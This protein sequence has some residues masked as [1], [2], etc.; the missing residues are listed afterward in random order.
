MLKRLLG[1]YYQKMKE[2]ILRSKLRRCVISWIYLGMCKLHIPDNPLTNMAMKYLILIL[3]PL[4]LSLL[5]CRD[6]SMAA[7][8]K[9]SNLPIIVDLEPSVLETIYLED[10]IDSVWY[11]PLE[12]KENSV[13]GKITKVLF[14]KEKIFICDAEITH[15]IFCFNHSGKALFV[16]RDRGRG[17][18]QYL[19]LT[20]FDV[21]TLNRE[22]VIYDA[23]QRAFLKYDFSGGFVSKHI[24][25]Y[26]FDDFRILDDSRAIAYSQY[27]P[28]PSLKDQ[29][30]STVFIFNYKTRKPESTFLSYN[31]SL[32][33]FSKIQGLLNYVSSNEMD[34]YFYDYLT[35]S[36]YSFRNNKFSK[37]WQLDYGRKNIP[38]EFWADATFDS[39]LEQINAGNFCGGVI[40]FQVLEKWVIGLFPYLSKSNIFIVSRGTHESFL[41]KEKVKS[42]K[43]GVPI[44]FV[45]PF[46]T[47]G[48]EVVVVIEPAWIS[49]I[50]SANKLDVSILPMLK[51]VEINSNPILQVTRLK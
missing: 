45:P 23:Q 27:I 43:S 11:I 35:N 20:G 26:V 47:T 36:I 49:G 34:H 42:W 8:D 24:H 48:R 18:G 4:L 30:N 33:L 50:L 44:F 37:D 5:G 17:P 41:L 13:I 14:T 32:D 9:E 51:N 38:N 2:M 19:T 29:E 16:I 25:G 6:R 1:V 7:Y 22:V 28:N 3:I 40:N 21:D 39:H 10:L 15:S 31:G 46:H 12:T